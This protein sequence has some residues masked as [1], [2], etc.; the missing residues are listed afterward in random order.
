MSEPSRNFTV[1]LAVIGSG[2]AGFA[3]SVFALNRGI[4]TAV[5][6]NTGAVAYTTGYLDLLGRLDGSTTAVD[7]PWQAQAA[8]R[9]AQPRHPLSRVAAADIRS[10]FDEFTAFLGEHGIAYTRAGRAQHH[11]ADPRRH[12]EADA[13]RSGDH[14]RGTEGAGRKGALRDRRLRRPEGLQW[15]R[16]RGQPRAAL[17][18]PLPRGGSRSRAWRAARCTRR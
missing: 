1:D 12:A 9:E 17:A 5:A 18:G 13:L 3:A 14:G 7:D 16:G 8:L 6:G 10:G 11:G 15:P 4:V 2:I